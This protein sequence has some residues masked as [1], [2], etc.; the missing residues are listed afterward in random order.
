MSPGNVQ[1]VL[2][3]FAYEEPVQQLWPGLPVAVAGTTTATVAFVGQAC[4]APYHSSSETIRSDSI[5][6]AFSGSARLYGAHN[7]VWARRRS[8][9]RRTSTSRDS[10]CCAGPHGQTR[11]KTG[12]A[13]GRQRNTRRCIQAADNFFSGNAVVDEPCENPQH[14]RRRYRANDKPPR[15]KIPLCHTVGYRLAAITIGDRAVDDELLKQTFMAERIFSTF[16]VPANWSISAWAA[17]NCSQ[18]CLSWVSI[19][20]FTKMQRICSDLWTSSTNSNVL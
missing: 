15:R 18:P 20:D 10:A 7:L 12:R 17:S 6:L 13:L 16:A 5:C 4:C 3:R 19:P 14:D 2:M 8:H 1:H 9:D 11:P